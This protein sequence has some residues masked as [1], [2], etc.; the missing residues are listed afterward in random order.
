MPG[1]AINFSQAGGSLRID[2]AG[3]WWARMNLAERKQYTD[4]LENRNEIHAG[5]DENFGDRKNEL[6]FIGQEMHGQNL[7]RSLEEC[8]LTS[9]EII[10]YQNNILFKNPFEHFLG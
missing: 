5:W 9:T 7:K 3:I 1:Q 8:L 10:N 4:Y 2:S 6:V